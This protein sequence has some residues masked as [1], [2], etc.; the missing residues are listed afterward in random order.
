MRRLSQPER[1]ALNR[2]GIFCRPS[3]TCRTRWEAWAARKTIGDQ[4]LRIFIKRLSVRVMTKVMRQARE[5][6]HDREDEEGSNGGTGSNYKHT[7][8]RKIEIPVFEGED[9]YER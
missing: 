2:L 8:F 1:K 4:D 7:D 9:A 3:G 5:E 6:R